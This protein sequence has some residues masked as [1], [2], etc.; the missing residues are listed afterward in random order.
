MKIEKNVALHGRNTF[1]LPSVAA[2]FASINSEDDLLQAL[3]FA[4]EHTLDIAVLGGGSNVLLAPE[5]TKTLVLG[6]AIPGRQCRIEDSAVLVTLGAGENWHDTVTWS[7]KEGYGGIESLALIPGLVGA[8]PVQN[9]GAYGTEIKDVLQQVRAYDCQSQHFVTLS[10]EECRFSYRDSLFKCSPG[11]YIITELVL[12]LAVGSTPCITHDGLKAYL[13]HLS[14]QS[15]TLDSVY[16]AVCEL[17]RAKLP[18]PAVTGNAGSF[19]KNPLVSLSHYNRLKARFPELVGYPDAKGQVKL[20][21]G[22]LI[23]SC[24]WK[25][26]VQGGVGVHDRQAL[27]LVNK[28]GAELRELLQFADKVVES[29]DKKFS[30]KLEREPQLFP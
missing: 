3:D 22:W 20:A 18:D 10:V 15:C 25:G 28:G 29:V 30:V 13:G 8:A 24:G 2:F 19:F 9:I 5:I 27:V 1:G 6:I 4:R 11:R 14:P 17:R 16:Q 23:E 26:L 7:V 12:K 21:A